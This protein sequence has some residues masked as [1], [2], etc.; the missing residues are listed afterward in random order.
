MGGKSYV[1]LFSGLRGRACG[2]SWCMA[3]DVMAILERRSMSCNLR[4]SVRRE[5][6]L[7]VKEMC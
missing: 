2:T 4:I 6:G 5:G 3:I 7:N 1:W